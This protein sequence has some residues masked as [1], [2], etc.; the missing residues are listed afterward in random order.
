[1]YTNLEHGW[2]GLSMGALAKALS[3]KVTVIIVTEPRPDDY[4]SGHASG[5]P[6]AGRG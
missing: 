2:I 6:L 5:L 4:G 1:M 3:A